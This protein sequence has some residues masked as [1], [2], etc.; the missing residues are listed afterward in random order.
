MAFDD[1]S[2][3]PQDGDD[4]PPAGLPL[5][6]D[7]R[8]WRHPS[9]VGREMRALPVPLVEHPEPPAP[10]RRWRRGGGLVVVGVVSG[11]LTATLMLGGLAL[12]GA[13]DRRVIERV[14]EPQGTPRAFEA[15]TQPA[16]LANGAPDVAAVARRVEPALARLEVT[17]Q[18]GRQTGTAVAVRTDG[19][20]LTSADVLAGATDVSLV[21]G[22]G[23][24]VP[25]TLVGVDRVTNLGVL[26]ISGHAT[27]VPTWG[28]SSGLMF[29]SDA[30]VVG[31]AE[32]NAR[33]PSVAKGV[34][35][36]IGATYVLD[37]G[38]TL[39]D[40]VQTDANMVRGTKG[41]VLLS[42]SGAVVG[43]I[44][45]V[46]K[47][48]AGVERTGFAMPIEY[49]RALAESYIQ[50]GHPSPVWLGIV[51]RTL[52]RAQADGLGIPGGVQ[53]DTIAP[54]SPAQLAGIA[55]GD[56]IVAVNNEPVDTWSAMNLVL[57]RLD[58]GDLL[59]LTIQRGS[60]TVQTLTYVARQPETYTDLPVQ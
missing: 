14:Y 45:T 43:I 57:R 9:E 49:A 26:R 44:T 22:D 23:E 54:Q 36:A 19:V 53:V 16:L 8:L 27:T 60:D 11:L 3:G 47:D 35:S 25:A 21:L 15:A 33:S 12:S 34:V 52:P 5:H 13:F 58:P 38:T 10:R 32:Q 28:D 24:K 41:G 56:I 31:A 59:P 39:H 2:S 48:E 42:G 50:Y 20:F 46:G 4:Q 6:P 1:P 29:G 51:G 18:V 37:D 7:D 17:T 30:V 55:A 40:L